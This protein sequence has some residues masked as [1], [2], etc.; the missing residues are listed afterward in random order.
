[1]AKTIELAF[2]VD[3]PTDGDTGQ[4]HHEVAD[5]LNHAARRIEYGAWSH[6]ER[7]PSGVVYA[8]VVNFPDKSGDKQNKV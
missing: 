4:A 8:V 1:M 6:V 5:A 3:L 2:S 7:R